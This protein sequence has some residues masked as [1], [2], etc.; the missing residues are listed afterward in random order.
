MARSV[1]II[2]GLAC[3]LAAPAGAAERGGRAF[4]RID[5]NGD[6]A[7]NRSEISAARDRWIARVDTN[8]DDLISR[9]EFVHAQS[10]RYPGALP[11]H[12]RVRRAR[13]FGRIDT[14]GDGFIDRL[15]RGASMT[16]WFRRRDANGD[17]RITRAEWL[18][19]W[20]RLKA[21]GGA[22]HATKRG[23]PTTGGQAA[24]GSSAANEKKAAR[25]LRRFDRNR[26]GAVSMSELRAVRAGR[27]RAIDRNADGRVSYDEFVYLRRGKANDRKSA[28]R[29]RRRALLFVRLDTNRDGYITPDEHAVAMRDWFRRTD[30]D[31][32][33][34]IT[35]NE[36][37]AARARRW[38]KRVGE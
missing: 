25:R 5:R 19:A 38:K 4:D 2:V 29:T 22:G 24:E 31:G 37:A 13:I 8:R 16:R 34:R 11:K 28:R 23:K 20:R 35:Y 21:W 3:A 14:D 36:L 15:E 26:D 32:D 9:K 30:A 1:A 18:A 12:V 7:V 17:G 6:R 33:G 27:M 10:R